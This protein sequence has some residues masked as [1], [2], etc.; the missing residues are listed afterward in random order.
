MERSG[1]RLP[2]GM[3]PLLAI[4]AV[5]EYYRLPWKPPV[6]AGLLAANTLIYLR[7]AFLRP[8]LPSI[9]DV[10]FNPYLILKDGDLKRFFLSAFYHVGESHLVYNMM[11]LLWKGIQLETSMGSVEFASMVAALL[12]MSQV[13]LNSQSDNY[14]HVH[15]LVVPARHAA[16]AELILI[17][18]FVPGVSFLGH[19]GGIL[20]GILYL[21]L[22]GI[23]SGSDPLTLII[24]NLTSILSWP[25][26]LVK[27]LFGPRQQQISGRG[28]VGGSQAGRAVLRVWRCQACT[29]DNY[30][31]SSVCEMC[32]NSLPSYR[33]PRQFDD[34]SL[35]EIRR[36]RIERFGR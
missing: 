28:T 3:L 18:M 1:G 15:G 31:S 19:L 12:T 36:R 22:K 10:W 35:E 5:S 11:S 32:G 24:K 23:Y 8:I 20:A 14:T 2:R 13:V 7:P 25:L 4:H 16:W 9:H 17:Q 6:T 30:S 33:L 26:R 21:K 29:Y 27:G 34:L